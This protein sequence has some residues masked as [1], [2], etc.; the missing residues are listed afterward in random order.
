M[1][2]KT[3]SHLCLFFSLFFLLWSVDSEANDFKSET[4]ALP[5]SIM[6]VVILQGSDYEMGYQ[7]GQ[8][9]GQYL[10]VRKESAWA[11]ALQNLSQE[12][13]LDVLKASQWHIKEYAPEA[14]EMM[15]GMAE[16]ARDSDFDLSF[17]DILLMNAGARIPGPTWTFPPGA[18]EEEIGMACSSWAAW[19][20]TTKDGRLICGDSQD[21]FFFHSLTI[22]AFPEEGNSFISPAIAGYLTHKPCMNNKGVCIGVTGGAGRR[23]VDHDF[24][25][26]FHTALH[27]MMRF[28]GSAEEAKDMLLSWKIAECTS[29]MISDVSG[30]AYVVEMTAAV[31]SVRNP[32]DYGEQ[33]FIYCTNNYF[34]ETMRNAIQGVEF[35]DHAGWLAEHSGKSSVSRNKELWTMFSRYHG[36]IDLDFAKMMWRFPGDPPPYPRDEE[37]MKT[38][39]ESRGQNWNPKICNLLNASVGIVIP[40][41]GDKGTMFICTGPA[42]K[43][44]YPSAPRDGAHFQIEGTHSFYELTLAS[45][46][47]EVVDKA[48]SAV[49]KSLFDLNRKFMQLKTTDTKHMALN[50]LFILAKTEYYQ[51]INWRNK[52]RLAEGHEILRDL[53]LAATAFTRSQAHARQC[54]NALIP[55]ATSP[56]DLGLSPYLETAGGEHKSGLDH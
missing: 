41:Q 56:E 55:P 28:A 33:D 16:G 3:S 22:V 20:Q 15:K 2:K 45:T 27:H 46:P 40:D 25:L 11:Q 38:Y 43:I 17:T 10:M 12:K 36:T 34:Q 8:Q 6:P 48:W 4:G 9:A 30:N 14:I 19:G 31:K 5:P 23:D 42:G 52:S 39:R 26:P 49:Y 24:G 53:A 54:L 50:D 1:R 7:Y 29:W 18:M 35:I 13:I 47:A 21:R 44:A 51:G 37:F 32:G